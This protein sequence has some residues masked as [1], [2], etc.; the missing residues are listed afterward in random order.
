MVFGKGSMGFGSLSTKKASDNFSLS[1]KVKIN[2]VQATL[3]WEFE[4]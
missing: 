1:P 2:F 4:D 3:Y